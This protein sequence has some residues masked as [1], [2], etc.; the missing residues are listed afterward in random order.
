MS[1]ERNKFDVEER[2]IEFAVRVYMKM[3][4]QH[5]TSNV[6]HRI[7]MSLRSPK[8]LRENE[9]RVLSHFHVLLRP[10]GLEVIIGEIIQIEIGIAIETAWNQGNW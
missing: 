2:L 9:C 3:N 8:Y 4:V 10:Q 6:Q 5:R 7:M 1:K